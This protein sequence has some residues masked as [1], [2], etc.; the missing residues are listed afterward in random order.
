M[1]PL[2]EAPATPQNPRGLGDPADPP[3][4][5]HPLKDGRLERR[6]I[7]A[8]WAIEPALGPDAAR[9]LHTYQR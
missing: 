9:C 8:G 4:T 2:T 7:R 6:V 5:F 3:T 1:N